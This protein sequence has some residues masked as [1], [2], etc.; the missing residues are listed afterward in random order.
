MIVPN[1]NFNL[2]MML[3]KGSVEI[4]YPYWLQAQLGLI[5][6]L[7]GRLNEENFQEVIPGTEFEPI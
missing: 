6:I 1:D 5:K 7:N 3:L 4:R 2:W